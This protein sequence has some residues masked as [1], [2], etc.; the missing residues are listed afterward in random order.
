MTIENGAAEAANDTTL[1]NQNADQTQAKEN[2]E[3]TAGENQESDGEGQP[4][5]DEEI[6]VEGEKFSIPRKVREAIAKPFQA[7]YTRK[8]QEVADGR[9]ALDSDRENFTKAQ[10]S[11]QK[12][13][14]DAAKV[15]AVNS[16]ISA[17]D[18]QINQYSQVNWTQLAQENPDA[19]QQH[20]VNYDN[21][22]D[23]KAALTQERDTAARAWTQKEQEYAEQSNRERGER[24]AKAQAEM[25]K[26]IEGF[27]SDLEQK[28]KKFG[29][30]QGLSDKDMAEAII[31]NPKFAKLIHIAFK[32]EEAAKAAKTQQTFDQQQQA[33]PVTRIG[34]SGGSAA[35]RTTDSSGDALS[36]D[37]WVK[38][39][40][41]RMRKKA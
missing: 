1:A 17:L 3:V 19:Y 11:R 35:R 41:E 9:R 2:T 12:H 5:D 23:R 24:I 29:N 20:R 10:E 15:Y 33:K 38:R 8:T 32:A 39:E 4:S 37:E 26:L 36:A 28:L 18:A 27:N 25:P 34:G 14:E 6:D 40:R 22:R 21:L 7:D 31:Q 13:F 30:D 16:Q